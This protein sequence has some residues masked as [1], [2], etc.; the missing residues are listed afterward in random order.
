MIILQDSADISVGISAAVESYTIGTVPLGVESSD[1]NATVEDSDHSSC[2][3]TSCKYCVKNLTVMSASTYS[4]YVTASDFL[5]DG[6][7]SDRTA[8]T[9]TPIS[10]E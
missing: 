10:K 4:I 9:D 3:S 7:Y 5:S 2:T 1:I 6:Y 8:C